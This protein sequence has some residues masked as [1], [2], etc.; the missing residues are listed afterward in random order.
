MGILGLKGNVTFS[1][2]V[3]AEGV[4]NLLFYF[5]GTSDALLSKYSSI[6]K[7]KGLSDASLLYPKHRQENKGLG[8]IYTVEMLMSPEFL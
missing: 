5:I 6:W 1:S 8:Q 2:L 7:M 3:W 4:M